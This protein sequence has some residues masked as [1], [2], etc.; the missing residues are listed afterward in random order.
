MRTRPETPADHEAIRDINIASFR[1][2]PFSR[3]TEHLIVEEL[4]KARALTFSLVA[5]TDEG[6]VVGYLAFSR[7]LIDGRFS[8]WLLA[9][10]LAVLPDYQRRG[11]GTALMKAGMAEII[12]IGTN[13]CI[14]VGDPAYYTRFGFI[15]DDSFVYEGVPPENVMILPFVNPPVGGK[16]SHHPA[17]AAGL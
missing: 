2:N 11:Y 5:E 12:K 13:G 15:R 14:L 8:G 6:K 17:F 7:A 1:H 4:R 9:G 3:Q 16:I 10:P